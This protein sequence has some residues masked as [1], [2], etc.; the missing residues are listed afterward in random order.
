M[1]RLL[2]IYIPT[3][4]RKNELRQCLE[5][6]IPQLRKYSLPLY[7]CDTSN[8]GTQDMLSK[9]KKKYQYLFYKH[10][11]PATFSTNARRALGLGRTDYFWLL[12]DDDIIEAD[13]I[14]TILHEIKQK[15]DFL[16]INNQPF[17]K[18]MMRK[19]GPPSINNEHD[20]VY[21]PGEHEKVLLNAKNGY[22]AFVG[23]IISTKKRFDK[24]VKETKADNP[25]FFP[26]VLMWKTIVGRRGKFI[27]RPLIKYR[28][29]GH[30]NGRASE[31]WLLKYP[32]A[33]NALKPEYSE[34]TIRLASKRMDLLV[35]VAINGRDFPEKRRSIND[36][37]NK[38]KVL[39]PLEK[40]AAKLI[41]KLYRPKPKS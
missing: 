2:G 8:D 40:V 1:N 29:G 7:I 35:I 17:S 39:N 31:I 21:E 12:G 37:I 30:L 20:V 27:S 10:F 24:A 16:Q 18:D 38:S 36:A 13:A 26:S 5:S 3:Y 33:I 22:P 41:L 6:L 23:G 28:T 11:P 4:N 25:D 15:F 32:Q 9:L 19:S 14:E 34:R